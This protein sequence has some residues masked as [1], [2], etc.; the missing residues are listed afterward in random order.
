LLLD[1]FIKRYA[2]KTGKT[3][4]GVSK[5]TI[6]LFKSYSWPGNIREL[7]NVIERSMILCENDIFSVDESWLTR[8]SVPPLRSSNLSDKLR[9]EEKRAIEAALNESKGRIAGRAGAAIKL[10]IPSSTLESKIKLLGIRKSA[11]RRN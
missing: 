4:R 8:A 9:N 10:G 5:K 6:E 7:Q 3:I 1:Y 11:F 2:D